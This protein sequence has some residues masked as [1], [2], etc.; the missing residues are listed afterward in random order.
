MTGFYENLD[1]N[2]S[3]SGALRNAKLQFLKEADGLIAHPANWSAFVLNG[4]DLTFQ[5]ESQKSYWIYSILAF[6]IILLTLAYLKR[7]N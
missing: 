2:Q 3:T 4:Q 7:K 6:V 5:D 1:K